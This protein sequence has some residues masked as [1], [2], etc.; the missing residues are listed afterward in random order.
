MKIL[1]RRYVNQLQCLAESLQQL[2]A[3]IQAIIEDLEDLEREVYDSVE[4]QNTLIERAT[5]L[6]S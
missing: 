5:R 4:I 2:D 1:L 6:K 3:K